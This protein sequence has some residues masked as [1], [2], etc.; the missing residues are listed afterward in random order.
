MKP[1]KFNQKLKNILVLRLESVKAVLEVVKSKREFRI[2]AS[3]TIAKLA[4]TA[5]VTLPFVCVLVAKK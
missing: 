3:V 2:I 5:L 1:V 4:I